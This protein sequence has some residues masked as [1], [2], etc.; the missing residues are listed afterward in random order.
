MAEA[1][2]YRDPGVS[3]RGGAGRRTFFPLHGG[4]EARLFAPLSGFP[5]SLT[6]GPAAFS[7]GLP[8]ALRAPIK[9][10]SRSTCRAARQ[11]APRTKK[12]DR[13]GTAYLGSSFP[14]F[15]CGFP[16]PPPPV[17][18][19]NP[20]G[21]TGAAGYAVEARGLA[22]GGSLP[23]PSSRK[24]KATEASDHYCPLK[25][26][27]PPQNGGLVGARCIFRIIGTR[28]C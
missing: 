11:Q 25:I 13:E 19:L 16:R 28:A 12:D 14:T 27:P 7:H 6:Y 26:F 9:R 5:P 8:D 10:G 23:S 1:A 17:P 24:L 21:E 15:H 20:E 4:R 22:I 18:P 2:G 3:S